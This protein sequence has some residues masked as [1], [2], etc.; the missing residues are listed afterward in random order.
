M[1][2]NS[3]EQ[4]QPLRA[5]PLKNW[6]PL[7]QGWLILCS[8]REREG[9]PELLPAT[10]WNAEGTKLVEVLCR[11]PQLWAH[12]YNDHD[13]RFK[14][15]LFAAHLPTL[16]ILHSFYFYKMR[17]FS[18]RT[19]HST[20]LMLWALTFGGFLYYLPLLL[21]EGPLIIAVCNTNLFRRQFVNLI[22]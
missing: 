14:Q 10:L 2:A 22:T 6:H 17:W 19:N 16:W 15:K 7:L 18:W 12:E 1:R 4:R 20:L 11:Y 13:V 5:T 3:L 9:C 8:P 21:Y